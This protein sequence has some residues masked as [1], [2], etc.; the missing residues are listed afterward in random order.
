MTIFGIISQ[1]F[2]KPFAT[3][4][5]DNDEPVEAHYTLDDQPVAVGDTVTIYSG[6]WYNWRQ[7]RV[8]A[9]CDNPY[10]GQSGMMAYVVSLEGEPFWTEYVAVE[11]SLS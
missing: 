2:D 3:E 8:E 9:I 7:G 1:I 6:Q 4:R 5:F 10:Y 11:V